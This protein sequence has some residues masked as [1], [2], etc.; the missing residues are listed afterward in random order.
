MIDLLN[1]LAELDEE[2]LHLDPEHPADLDE[3]HRIAD[4]MER[5]EDLLAETIRGRARPLGENL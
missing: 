4:E 3:L 2:T 5:L 1:R